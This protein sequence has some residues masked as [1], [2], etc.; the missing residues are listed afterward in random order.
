M[1]NPD[2]FNYFPMVTTGADMAPF[3]DVQMPKGGA[4]Y[5]AG[6]GTI[7]R[8]E[9]GSESVLWAKDHGFGNDGLVR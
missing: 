9:L 1:Y 8:Q 3:T 5:I 2:K 4:D 6:D 7:Q